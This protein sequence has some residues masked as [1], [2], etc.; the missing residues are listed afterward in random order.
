MHDL[1]ILA[2][3]VGQVGDSNVGEHD[4]SLHVVT[5]ILLLPRSWGKKVH[6]T[7]SIENRAGYCRTLESKPNLG[8]KTGA[9]CIAPK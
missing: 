5:I 9:R 2:R 6:D 1:S 3:A 7:P 8:V 4:P